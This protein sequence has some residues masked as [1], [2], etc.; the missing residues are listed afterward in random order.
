M[1]IRHQKISGEDNT[2]PDLVGGEDWDADH[3]LGEDTMLPVSATSL[4]WN[5]GYST[6][7]TYARSRGTSLVTRDSAGVYYF[8]FNDGVPPI[9]AGTARYY[10]AI[11]SSSPRG[12]WPAGWR[13]E[14]SVADGAV[15]LR[16][17]DDSNTP[18]D[19]TLSVDF[20]VTVFLCVDP[21]G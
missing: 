16:V 20:T 15:T 7:S 3:A 14:V 13:S 1:T 9:V 8:T 21:A 18:A 12:S 11:H 10:T 6:M 5:S 2:D 17:F 19:P 4:V